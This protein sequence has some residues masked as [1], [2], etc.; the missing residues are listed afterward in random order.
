MH[1]RVSTGEPREPQHNKRCSLSLFLNAVVPLWRHRVNSGRNT[2]LRTLATLVIAI[3]PL[4]AQALQ[5]I[6]LV[7]EQNSETD[8]AGYN[9]HYGTESRVYSSVSH[10]GNVNAAFVPNLVEGR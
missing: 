7:W 2:F 9:L 4:P 8:L 6:R 3:S 10:L 5:T 1:V